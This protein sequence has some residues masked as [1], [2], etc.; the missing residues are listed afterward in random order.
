MRRPS[1][2]TW[3]FAHLGPHLQFPYFT[4]T[5]VSWG[6]G[7]RP[8]PWYDIAHLCEV[9]ADGLR[10]SAEVVAKRTSI[11]RLACALTKELARNVRRI[12]QQC[13]P[14]YGTATVIFWRSC[15]TYSAGFGVH[16]SGEWASWDSSGL[17][18]RRSDCRSGRDREIRAWYG[19]ST[20]CEVVLK[21]VR[22]RQGAN[23]GSNVARGKKK[24]KM[25]NG[26]RG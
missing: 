5:M 8:R 18:W 23:R 12:Y 14:E 4:K 3:I 17:R 9:F 1:G 10:G 25:R 15:A 7:R 11:A 6:C 26:K 19:G 13:Q 21:A 16:R 20:K 2:R 22:Q 24:Q